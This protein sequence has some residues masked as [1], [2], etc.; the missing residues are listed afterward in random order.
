MTATPAQHERI[1]ELLARTDVQDRAPMPVRTFVI[2]NRPVTEVLATLQRLIA[3]GVLSADAESQARSAVREGADQWSY[4]PPI[5]LA[6]PTTPILPGTLPAAP[7]PAPNADASSG[8]SGN[9]G[10]GS[11]GS[12]VR[13]SPIASA[14]S[15]GAARGSA[16]AGGIGSPPGISL[17]AD[18][19]TN[20][21]IAIGD[22][23][24]LAQI[25]QLLAT[26]DVR[27]PQLLLEVILVSLS[28]SEALSLGVELEKLGGINSTTIRLSSLFGL[29]GGTPEQRTVGD[30]RG[31]TGVVLNPG[32]FT[33]VVRALESINKTNSLS[34]P[35]LLVTNNQRAV[36]S[37]VLQQP[38][39][40]QTRSTTNDTTFSYG[41]SESAGTT[42]SVQPQI[43]RGDHLLL[44][45]SIKLSS[46]VGASS[47]AGLPPPK[48]E[49]SVDSVASVPDG[50]TVV[51]GGL[52]LVTQTEV[53]SRVPILG[54]IPIVGELFKTRDTGHGRTRFYVFIRAEV[55]RGSS[56][57]RLKHMS[58]SDLQ[59]MHVDDGFP[60]VE[61]RYMR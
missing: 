31:F 50:F 33:F 48:Q 22:A 44:T 59:A 1:A 56:F 19:A 57:D 21:L 16:R 17:T 11:P 28:D 37:S 47:A 60:E 29:S 54:S 12:S 4:R 38:I 26:I 14:S 40:Q 45:Y 43:A 49:N 6:T 18:E 7:A 42:I 58:S 27:Q 15:P 53:E 39:T 34:K 51:V 30:G 41:G 3:A 46:F 8:T 61:P 32:E 36:F 10:A 2:S 9:G 24:V 52:D 5:P 23:R 13:S 55:L 35:K 20:S 25:E